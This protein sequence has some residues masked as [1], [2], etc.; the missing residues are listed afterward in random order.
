MK[1]LIQVPMH[2]TGT[3]EVQHH[4]MLRLQVGKSTTRFWG[5]L[6]PLFSPYPWKTETISL[7]KCP[8][9]LLWPTKGWAVE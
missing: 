9:V 3:K 1:D 6:A 5:V 8:K 7:G 2:K 4:H